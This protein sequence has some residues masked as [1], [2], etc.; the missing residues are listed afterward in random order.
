M[1]LSP[2]VDMECYMVGYPTLR[3]IPFRSE[4]KEARVT[5]FTRPSDKETLVLLLKPRPPPDAMA[6][7]KPVAAG[8]LVGKSVWVDW[9]HLREA[10]VVAVSSAGCRYTDKGTVKYS[11]QISAAWRQHAADAKH[12][13]M[14]KRGIDINGVTCMV[15]V[16]KLIGTRTAYG[17][18][19]DAK[20]EK[21]WSPEEVA[22]PWQLVV[23]DIRSI[24]NVVA[25]VDFADKFA[26]GTKVVKTLKKFRGCVGTVVNFNPDAFQL[27]IQLENHVAPN[28]QFVASKGQ[29]SEFVPFHHATRAAN[30]SPSVMGRLICSV[31]VYD[32]T[33]GKPEQKKRDLGLK[34][35]FAKREE[36]VMGFT[37]CVGE[38][39]WEVSQM[40]ISILKEFKSRF[41]QFIAGMNN[42]SGNGDVYIGDI[43]RDGSGATMVKAI[44]DWQKSLPCYN[45]DR[46]PCGTTYLDMA[47]LSKLVMSQAAT[48]A[49]TEAPEVV[50]V[51]KVCVCVCAV[52][53]CAVRLQPPGAGCAWVDVPRQFPL[54]H[55]FSHWCG[56]FLR[57]SC[58]RFTSWTGRDHRPPRRRSSSVTE[59][60][61][62]TALHPSHLAPAATSSA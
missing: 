30:I 62:S 46:V 45:A 22:V 18:R 31:Y 10:L 35:K 7:G 41:P 21:L 14:F 44:Q 29:S 3:H 37:R 20:L 38:R 17:A 16:R 61:T 28:F 42:V 9:P 39:K 36:E 6:L 4:L 8:G 58:T 1:L 33:S 59:S 55:I 60:S 25:A 24:Q 53:K 11:S 40:T 15:H 5:V 12:T 26:P 52:H 47:N 48:T 43:C 23:D 34:L 56:A 57:Y 19:G 27:H 54:D 2:G 32:G 13:W 50:E 51:H 49:A